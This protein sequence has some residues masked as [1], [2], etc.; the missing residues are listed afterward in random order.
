MTYSR[1]YTYTVTFGHWSCNR[2]LA[3]GQ[4]DSVYYTPCIRPRPFLLYLPVERVNGRTDSSATEPT[5]QCVITTTPS[6]PRYS[7]SFIVFIS[8]LPN[9]RSSGNIFPLLHQHLLE[10]QFCDPE[11]PPR[12]IRGELILYFRS[13]V[14]TQQTTK[15]KTS[16]LKLQTCGAPHVGSARMNEARVD[17]NRI[18]NTA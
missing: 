12:I 6:V 3:M 2:Y 13:L 4:S 14:I 9:Q 17:T 11:H 1:C 18:I 16:S 10:T 15:F 8:K 7:S 5:G